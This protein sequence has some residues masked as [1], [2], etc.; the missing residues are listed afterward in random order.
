MFKSNSQ[1]TIVDL[2]T[3]ILPRDV[4]GFP[5]CTSDESSSTCFTGGLGEFS[6]LLNAEVNSADCSHLLPWFRLPREGMLIDKEFSHF[7]ENDELSAFCLKAEDTTLSPFKP[8][9]YAKTQLSIAPCSKFNLQSQYRASCVKR[10]I[11]LARY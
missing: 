10:K 1:D 7:Y 6:L 3:K 11:I 8:I 5:N 4:W 9:T 2:E